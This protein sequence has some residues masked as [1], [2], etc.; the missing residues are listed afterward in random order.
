MPM[1]T[2][3]TRSCDVLVLGSGLAG[4]RAGISALEEN[5]RLQVVLVTRSQGPSGSSFTNRNNRLGMVVC[6]NDEEAAA[7]TRT[8]AAI[9]P[10]GILRPGLPALMARESAS[11][12]HDLVNTGFHFIRDRQGLFER[13]SCCFLQASRLA[14]VFTDLVQAWDALSRRF[15]AAGGVLVQGYTLKDLVPGDKDSI[16]GAVFEKE[17]AG[18]HLAVQ[19]RALILASGGSAGLFSRHLTPSENLGFATALMGR[20]GI[21]LV[22]M[23]F[24]QHLWYETKTLAH[25]PCWTMAEPF[26]LAGSPDGEP[27]PVPDEIRN[28]CRER[29][30]HVPMAHGCSDSSIDRF[31]LSRRNEDGTVWIFSPDK[32]WFTI[33]PFAHAMNGGVEIDETGETM[34]KGLFACGECAGGMHGANRIG[35]AMVLATQVFGSRAGVYAARHAEG[36]HLKPPGLFMASVKDRLTL[37][38]RDEGE[39]VKGLSLI[40]KTLTAL[41][42]PFPMPGRKAAADTLRRIQARSTDWR[43]DLAVETALMI[44]GAHVE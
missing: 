30:R 9:A 33:A 12:F 13:H 40:R 36:Q 5:P 23:S 2:P 16:Q 39:W 7:F 26:V 18:V 41:S 19:A 15:L 42:G 3:N 25:W 28:L 4:L 43:L 31:L 29:S 21:P 1:T 6:Q 35:G 27:G 17:T 8:A 20:L 32:G 11:L 24:V 38:R 37:L 10:P 34:M 22:N 44:T 14:S